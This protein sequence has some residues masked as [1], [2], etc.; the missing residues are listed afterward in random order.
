MRM[1]RRDHMAEPIRRVITGKDRTGKAIILSDSAAANV[2]T[3]QGSTTTSTL[4]WVTDSTPAALT[5]DAD[6]ADR[7]IGIPPPDGGT[8]FRI[9]EFG[10]DKHA[11]ADAATQH[12]RLR[13]M[14]VAP[15]GEQAQ[16]PRHPGMHRTRTI[17]YAIVLSGE[18]DMLLDDSEVHVKA[19]DVVIQRGTNHA[20]V[21]RGDIPCRIAFVLIDGKD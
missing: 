11:T 13:E 16:T 12:A 9:V 8:V 6:P 14:G 15:E 2:Q 3:R 19:G 1:K 20:W 18:I 5:G 7:R 10:P 4:L 21:N 17:D